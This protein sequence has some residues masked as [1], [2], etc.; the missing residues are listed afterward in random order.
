MRGDWTLEFADPAVCPQQVDGSS[1]SLSTFMVAD[2]LSLDLQLDFSKGAGH[3]ECC[4]EQMALKILERK[5]GKQFNPC[6]CTDN[7]TVPI[8][9]SLEEEDS[10]SGVL[11]GRFP[12]P[13]SPVV[14][15]TS[16]CVGGCRMYERWSE[17][18]Q[19]ASLY[20]TK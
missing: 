10:Q 18:Y 4:R 16:Y 11:A 2:C 7:K 9:E 1:C 20:K 5:D 8:L 12:Y 3:F 15:N 19:N 14:H 6:L 17:L 13:T